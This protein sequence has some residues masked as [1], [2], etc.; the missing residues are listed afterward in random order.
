MEDFVPRRRRRQSS[1]WNV[2]LLSKIALGAFIA[3]LVG[4]VAIFLLFIW[5][6]RDLPA[7]GK[8]VSSANL[9][10]S[11]QIFDRNNQLLYA[12]HDR[13][14]Q[15]RIYV[16]LPTIPK[17]IQ[18]ATI[19]IEDKNFYKN[20]GF[21]TISYLR[22]VRD[23]IVYHR[24]TGGSGLTQQLV[25]NVLLGSERTLPRKMKELLLSIQVDKTYTKDQIL[26]MY[27]N[28]VPYGGPTVGVEAASQYYFG[29]H[30]KDLDLA[31]SAF[32]AGL[33][34]GPSIYSPYT[35]HTYYIDRTQAVLTQMAA[36]KYITQS[37][38]DSALAEIKNKKFS[39]LNLTIKAPWFIDY[40][41]RELVSKFG[42]AMVET[43]GLQVTTTLDYTL[44]K[45][46]EDIVKQEIDKIKAYHVDNGAAMVTNPKTG[47]ILVMVGNKDFSDNAINGQYNVATANTEDPKAG[48]QPGSSLKPIIYADAF[49]KGYTAASVIMDV[50]T[51]FTTGNPVDKDYTPVN[52]D[53]KFHGPVSVRMSLANSFNIPAVKMLARVGIKDAMSL[54]YQMGITSWNPTPTTLAN[55][56]YSLVLGGQITDLYQEATAYGVFANG[57][58]RQD[59]VSILK[60][61]DAHGNTLYENHKVDGIRVL[62]PEI[63]FVISHILTDDNARSLEFGPHSYLEISGRQVAVKTG[64]TDEKRDNWT[65]GY[66]PSYVVGVWVGNHDNSPMNQKIAS[67]ITGAS[68][69]WNKIMTAVLKGKPN[70]TFAQP[71]GVVTLQVDAVGGGIHKDG[72]PDKAE[73]FVKGTQPQGLAS[74]YQKLKVSRH[75]SNKLANADEIS[76]GDYDTKDFIV[77]REDDPIS[78]DGKN[79]W[80]EGIDAWIKTTYAA[81][82]PE[83]YPPKDTSDYKY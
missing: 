77:L 51:N 16:T 81:D 47:E 73:Y 8:L 25:K 26:E 19:A 6:S 62:S 13:N 5:Y 72:V 23:L 21:S 58:V 64:T 9:A 18:D 52:Y 32:L 49:T 55:V 60:V 3:L 41:K 48:R 67:G 82:H 7:P 1:P 11:T 61:T 74:I 80:Q 40:V 31:E 35:G 50:P 45:Q 78:T 83:Y 2:I 70:E 37:Q 66:T 53:G 39:S 28:D 57:G 44:E 63:S 69:I 38:A 71:D 15:S 46:S 20:P 65:V 54:G 30:V 34:Q 17:N 43:G 36:D 10:E 68:P 29:K 75:Q 27:L 4:I 33:P 76:H 42:S 12:V 56:G 22:V 59:L 24:V 79:R 14:D